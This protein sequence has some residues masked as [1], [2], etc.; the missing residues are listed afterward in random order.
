[1]STTD[2]ALIPATAAERWKY[3]ET[4]AD[5]NL[6][7]EVFRRH[8]ADVFYAVE[9]GAMLGLSPIAALTGIH[10][11]EGKPSASASLM[12]GLVQAQGHKVRTSVTGTVAAGDI[13]A[14]CTVI[15]ADD[16]DHPFTSTWDLDRALRAELIDRLDVTPEGKTVVVHRTRKGLAGNW[17]KYT[18]SMLKARAKSEACRDAAEDALF[19]LHYTP[20]ELGAEV[21]EDGAPVDITATVVDVTPP[22]VARPPVQRPAPER[23]APAEAEVIDAEVEAPAARPASGPVERQAAR[24]AARKIQAAEAPAEPAPT[25][26]VQDPD[27]A[28]TVAGF[29]AVC[30]DADK[31]VATFQEAQARSLLTAPVTLH[32]DLLDVVGID[33]GKPLNLGTWLMA[34]G[35]YVRANGGMTV[36]EAATAGQIPTD[37][38]EVH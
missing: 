6:L 27:A 28:Q 22:T 29:A 36:T 17:Q 25:V 18:E 1:M 13:T 10:V 21:D 3:A 2:V 7:P 26:A 30:G 14:T 23:S 16:P 24:S 4:M 20:E 11:I 34:A 15:R 19:G 32:A 9:Y 38:E 12:A 37:T 5:A 8:P 31:L 35:K 33:P